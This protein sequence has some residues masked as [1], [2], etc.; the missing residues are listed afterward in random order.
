[1]FYENAFYLTTKGAGS[2]RR[3]S[4]SR[5]RPSSPLTPAFTAATSLGS[6]TATSARAR[7]SCSSCIAGFR[8]FEGAAFASGLVAA[9]MPLL[10]T[11]GAEAALQALILQKHGCFMVDLFMD[12]ATLQDFK[13]A[14]QE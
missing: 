4:G 5:V 1:V 6:F 11:Y 12:P 3:G 10:L 2:L 13:K 7:I 8:K 14:L 9:A